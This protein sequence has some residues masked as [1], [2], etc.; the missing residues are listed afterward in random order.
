MPHPSK[1]MAGGFQEFASITKSAGLE[2]LRW[3]VRSTTKAIQDRVLFPQRSLGIAKEMQSCFVSS[4]TS[5]IISFQLKVIVPPLLQDPCR[6]CTHN[7]CFFGKFLQLGKKKKGSCKGYKGSF[8]E[9]MGSSHHILRKI[10]RLSHLD[11]E[12]MEV[13]NAKKDSQKVLLSCL[14]SRQIWL[15]SV[16]DSCQSTY[17]TNLKK[18]QCPQ[19]Q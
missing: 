1:G 2:F 10:L 13:A 12:V 11:A 6:T 14:T 15:I 19:P 17:L 3:Q 4:G 18:K 5:F 7:Q 16:V 8:L 9:E